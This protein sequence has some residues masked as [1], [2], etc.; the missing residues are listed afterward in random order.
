MTHVGQ[1]GRSVRSPDGRT[2]VGLPAGLGSAKIAGMRWIVVGVI[3]G[4]A[5]TPAAAS[6]RRAGGVLTFGGSAGAF[7]FAS[8]CEACEPAPATGLEAGA[9]LI[10]SDRG[11]LAAGFA[12]AAGQRFGGE[13]KG[14][15][16]V[17][18]AMVRFWPEERLSFGLGVGT[19][20]EE[21]G[22]GNGVSGVGR[23]LAALA[24]VGYDVRRWSRSA[25]VVRLGAAGGEFRDGA[26]AQLGLTVA[27]DLFGVSAD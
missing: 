27:L 11:T 21:S 23:G 12:F 7:V 9:S 15:F 17:L 19:T 16:G 5:V 22:D 24:H 4:G 6:P 20:A 14:L 8:D 1:T 3:L 10:F 25:L 26:G 18:A 2:H 13:A